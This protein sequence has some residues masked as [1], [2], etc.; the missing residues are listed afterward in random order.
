M[1]AMVCE[2][3]DVRPKKLRTYIANGKW[4]WGSNGVIRRWQGNDDDEDDGCEGGVK[5]YFL[6]IFHKQACGG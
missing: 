2:S 5:K 1:R 3:V 4:K 6:F